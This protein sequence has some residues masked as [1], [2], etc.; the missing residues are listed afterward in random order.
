M[1]VEV[2]KTGPGTIALGET[3]TET[4]F[5]AQVTSI[6]LTPEVDEGD[7][8]TTLSGEIV[9]GEDQE[10]YTLSGTLFQDLRES[11]I[12]AYSWANKGTVVPFTFTPNT[13]AAASF[14]GEIK[15]RALAVGGDV[16]ANATSDFEWPCVGVPV[17]TWGTS[18]VQAASTSTPL[19]TSSTKTSKD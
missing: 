18:G 5:S 6:V 2:V 19:S 13:D 9:P 7:D 16:D 14:T 4:D 1:P 15:V 17:P 12:V 8:V 3:G 11:G 10:S